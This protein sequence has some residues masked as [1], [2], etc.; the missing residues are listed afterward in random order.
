MKKILAALL[1][2]FGASTVHAAT[3]VNYVVEPF[4]KAYWG[5]SG[6]NW[7]SIVANNSQNE[8]VRRAFNT[9][10]GIGTGFCWGGLKPMNQKAIAFSAEYPNTILNS[11]GW[12]D[13]IS[14]NSD[15]TGG[16]VMA[17]GRIY[18][19]FDTV[20]LGTEGPT[21]AV[22]A[23]NSS[24]IVNCTGAG[25][26]AI[27]DFGYQNV[28][29]TTDLQLAILIRS[30][31]AS[32]NG[33][34]YQSQSKSIPQNAW[35]ATWDLAS[36]TWQAVDTASTGAIDMDQCDS[37][38]GA[39]PS[40]SAYTLVAGTA[41]P[42]LSKVKGMGIVVTNPATNAGAN[43]LVTTMSLGSIPAAPA[44]PTGVT[45][46]PSGDGTS[47][48]LDWTDVSGATGYF[49]YRNTATGLAALNLANPQAPV[50]TSNYTDT[51]L[52]A[53]TTYYYYV[54]AVSGT[55]GY[56]QESDPSAEVIPGQSSEVKNW[57]RR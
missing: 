12:R 23:N 50:A 22:A 57:I 29:A 9:A 51:G 10:V 18:T 36:A 2:M 21:N 54:T 1:L 43:F 41:T 53:G 25:A 3:T 55:T 28:P 8:Q 40:Q 15:A 19:R 32:G 5:G 31:D 14:V 49:V 35:R 4:Y 37:N 34:W 52:T 46:V 45:A 20:D 11:A 17:G 13:G 44:A 16:P 39:A 7:Y 33:I 38:G 48:N 47:V 30:E 26:K 42:D 27:V 6:T 56:W 24:I